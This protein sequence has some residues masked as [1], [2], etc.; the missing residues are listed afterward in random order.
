MNAIKAPSVNLSLPDGLVLREARPSDLDG[1][2][3]LLTE[4]G[5]AADAVDHRLVVMD[6]EAGWSACAVVVDGDRVVST[7]TLLDEEVRIGGVELPAGQVELVATDREHEGRGLVRALMRWAH[8]RSADRGHVMQAMIGIPYFYRLFG[9][10][11]AIDIPQ[12]LTAAA[13]PPGEGSPVLRAARPAD[14]PAVAALQSAAQSG[15]DVAMPHS[16]PCLRWLTAH[17]ASTTWVLEEAGEVIATGRTTPPGGRPLLAE[18]AAR[19]ESSARALLRAVAALSPDSRVRVVHRA[20]TV[21][22]AAWRE[23]LE[24]EPRGQA[25]QYYVRI[26]DVPVLLDR[27]RPL[28]WERLTGAGAG[29]GAGPGTGPGSGTDRTGRDIVIST[30]GAHYRIPVLADGLGDIVTGGPMQNPGAVGGL[31]VAPDQ[32]PALL[33]GPHG[34]EGLSRIRPDVYAGDEEL[35][36]ALFPPLTADVLSYYLPY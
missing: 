8:D 4:R 1:I 18:A 26:P 17:D 32:L 11:Y 35:F 33:F 36:R 5:E 28:L 19:D 20:G 16:E 27:L 34:I 6:P 31:A 23:F 15:F 10:E 24:H 14:L 12:A 29:A 25:E 7:A 13:P 30:F 9:Y 2:G 22:A 21:T 3:A